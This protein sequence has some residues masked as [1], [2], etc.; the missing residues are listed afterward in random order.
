[1]MSYVLFCS[2]VK[3]NSPPT[4]NESMAPLLLLSLFN[5]GVT[6]HTS[7]KTAA[8]NPAVSVSNREILCGIDE[9]VPP[10]SGSIMGQSHEEFNIINDS[11][12]PQAEQLESGTSVCVMNVN[13]SEFSILNAKKYMRR[14]KVIQ[15]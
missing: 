3:E 12:L 11:G 1:M 7:S 10:A 14:A 15:K 2:S 5:S 4:D 13:P 6:T 9:K 8:K